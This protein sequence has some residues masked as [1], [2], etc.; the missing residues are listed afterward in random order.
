MY[1][2]KTCKIKKLVRLGMGCILMTTHCKTFYSSFIKKHFEHLP[3]N[4][5][6]NEMWLMANKFHPLW[7]NNEHKMDEIIHARR[8]KL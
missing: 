4:L 2:F 7:M 1:H 6:L 8:I 3:K 5:L